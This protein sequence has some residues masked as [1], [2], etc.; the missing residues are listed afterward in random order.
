[1]FLDEFFRGDGR[2]RTPAPVGSVLGGL[3]RPMPW[4]RRRA[5]RASPGTGHGSR[6]SWQG[7]SG[8]FQMDLSA[9]KCKPLSRVCKPFPV[10]VELSMEPTP[11]FGPKSGANPA[12]LWGDMDAPAL[13]HA[14]PGGQ[15]DRAKDT[16]RRGLAS[17]SS[18]A[19]RRSKRHPPIAGEGE[20]LT[21]ISRGAGTRSGSGIRLE[22]RRDAAACGQRPGA[23]RG[24]ARPLGS[25][26]AGR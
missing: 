23:I 13:S 12:V 20:G 2:Q 26:S 25:D 5:Q 24:D 14:G 8:R 11:A 10:W 22:S 7:K 21:P 17:P 3:R 6:E 4:P 16:C 9:N 15:N 1:M 19:R 18:A